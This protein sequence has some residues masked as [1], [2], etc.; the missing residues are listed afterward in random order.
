MTLMELR[1]TNTGKKVETAMWQILVLGLGI[2]VVAAAEFN[3]AWLL[4]WVATI[5]AVTKWLNTTYLQK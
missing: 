5:N 1:K 3:V 2:V 4:P